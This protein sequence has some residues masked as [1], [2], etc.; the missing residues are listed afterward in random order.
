MKSELI[1]DAEIKEIIKS[2]ITEVRGESM[3]QPSIDFLLSIRSYLKKL[4]GSD[5]KLIDNKINAYIQFIEKNN[6]KDAKE[7]FSDFKNQN[8]KRSEKINSFF[9]KPQEWIDKQQIEFEKELAKRKKESPQL[10]PY[11]E[12]KKVHLNIKYLIEKHI[13]NEKNL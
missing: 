12:S 5:E 3:N 2:L 4:Y 9:N 11:Y 1:G 8:Q 13:K 10:E 6:L 7:L